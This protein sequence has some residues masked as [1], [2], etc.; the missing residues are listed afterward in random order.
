MIVIDDLYF[1]YSKTDVFEGINLRMDKGHI[2]GILGKNGTGKSTLLYTIAGLLL[3]QKG[4]IQVLGFKPG[5]RHPEFLRDIF[6]I[7]EEFHLPDISIKDLIKYHSPFY[8]RF[9]KE[10][11]YN[12][13]EAFGIP[14]H[15][16]LKMSYGQK[17]KI[18]ISFGLAC[19]VSLLLMDEPTNGL[20]I[21][22]KSQFRKV[23]ISSLADHKCIAISSHQVQDLTN[24]IDHIII[25]D[26]TKVVLQQSMQAIGRKL[27]FKVTSDNFEVSTAFYSEPAFGGSSL[28]TVNHDGEEANINLEL[29]YK[30]I[31]SNPEGIQYA[32]KD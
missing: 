3:P 16:L 2:Y 25:L 24:L 28:V 23:L 6:M 32:L 4:D 30:A 13:L 21:I 5:D 19:N 31:M 11:F 15:T 17:K 26:N 14:D 1:A 20:D 22:S 10:E 29:F 12:N 27:A 9:D 18:L 7:P 8:P